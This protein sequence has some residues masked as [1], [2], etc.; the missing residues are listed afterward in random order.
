MLSLQRIVC[1]SSRWDSAISYLVWGTGNIMASDSDAGNESES[2]DLG[3]SRDSETHSSGNDSADDMSTDVCKICEQ[4][5]GAPDRDCPRGFEYIVSSKGGRA[6]EC[7][8]CYNARAGCFGRGETSIRQGT[9]STKNRKK[10]KGA[11]DGQNF[12]TLLKQQK[13]LRQR[14]FCVRKQW[15]VHRAQKGKNRRFT[16]AKL[17]LTDLLVRRKKEKYNDAFQPYKL[18]PLMTFC[19]NK[20]K[21]KVLKTDEERKKFVRSLN[22]DI[23]LN[24]KKVVRGAPRSDTVFDLDRVSVFPVKLE[25]DLGFM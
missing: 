17:K 23:S 5:F 9:F 21:G 20:K 11:A 15:V 24:S 14:F 3:D 7:E 4:K 12:P 13:K 19:K 1:N 6:Q 16:F 2:V 22:L 18:V 8:A 25:P 10:Q